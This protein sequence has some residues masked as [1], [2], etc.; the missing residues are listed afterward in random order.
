MWHEVS[1]DIGAR[2]VI[3]DVNP[4]AKYPTCQLSVIRHSKVD[5]NRVRELEAVC[6]FVDLIPHK[7]YVMPSRRPLGR[8][9]HFSRVS[10]YTRM[11][12]A[13]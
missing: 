12:I 7:G 10:E 11:V 5:V 6:D 3:E 9:D 1:I 2:S 4:I 8:F 13:I